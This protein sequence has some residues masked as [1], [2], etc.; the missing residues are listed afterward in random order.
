[1]F[2]QMLFGKNGGEAI[3]RQTLRDT[4][5]TQKAI[6]TVPFDRECIELSLSSLVMGNE[7]SYKNI[8]IILYYYFG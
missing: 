2:R 7:L 8:I 6:D 4:T 1:M 5:L 3:V